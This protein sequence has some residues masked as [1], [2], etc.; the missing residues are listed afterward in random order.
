VNPKEDKPNNDNDTNNTFQLL[1]KTKNQ[2]NN[3][4]KTVREK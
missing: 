1:L 2:E 3:P 4:E